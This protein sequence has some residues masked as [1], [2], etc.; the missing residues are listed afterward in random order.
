MNIIKKKLRSIKDN[1]ELH[2]ICLML[3]EDTRNRVGTENIDSTVL[4]KISKADIFLA[5]LT[6]I[7]TLQPKKKGKHV[8]LLPNP[9]VMYEYGYA[10]GIGL[11]NHCILLAYLNDGEN[12]EDLPFDVNH[13]TITGFHDIGQL[14]NLQDWVLKIIEL[15]DV[16]RANRKQYINAQLLFEGDVD[17]IRISPVY[18]RKQ[19]VPS[20]RT[21]HKNTEN[22]AT[23]SVT[24]F[25][26]SIDIFQSALDKVVARPAAVEV[27]K[28]INK[29]TFL[30]RCPL[31]LL[32]SNNETRPLH[33]CKV[34]ITCQLPAVSFHYSNE[35]HSFDFAHVLSAH[36]THVESNRVYHHW[37][38]FNPGETLSLNGFFISVPYD[39]ATIELSYV[40]ST[41]EGAAKGRLK[42]NV[43]PIFDDEFIENTYRYGEIVIEGKQISE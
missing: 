34:Y 26:S 33:N 24:P 20:S 21:H 28:P 39:V 3:D 11:M 9:N 41:A 31:H 30:D 22:L 16:E 2:D 6:P 27:V 7:S 38:M 5:D 14:D 8:K 4:E 18:V 12:T 37:Q 36:S 40:L 13:D 23:P 25:S 10:K 1:L 17:E 35:K 32:L 42:I 15:V 19:F 29:T 43:D